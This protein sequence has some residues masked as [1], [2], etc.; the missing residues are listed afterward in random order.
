MLTIGI[1][2]GGNTENVRVVSGAGFQ[3]PSPGCEATT[4][5]TPGP[6]KLKSVPART[7]GPLATA[8]RTSS[9]LVA[10]AE[11]DATDEAH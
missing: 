1:G 4:V 8:K 10:V 9:P 3:L 7:A 6:V 2:G 5:T 11:S